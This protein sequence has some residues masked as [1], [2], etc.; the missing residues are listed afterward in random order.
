MPGVKAKI[1]DFPGVLASLIAAAV[2][3]IFCPVIDFVWHYVFLEPPPK[4]AEATLPNICGAMMVLFA[5]VGG[6]AWTEWRSRQQL[7]K[8]STPPVDMEYKC[9]QDALSILFL[10]GMMQWLMWLQIIAIRFYLGQEYKLADNLPLLF[11]LIILNGSRWNKTLGDVIEG[12]VVSRQWMLF[13]ICFSVVHILSAHY[14]VIDLMSNSKLN[15]EIAQGNRSIDELNEK[16]NKYNGLTV[17]LRNLALKQAQQK[18]PLIARQQSLTKMLQSDIT[19]QLRRAAGDEL[20]QVKI[21]L[22]A[23]DRQIEFTLG[24]YNVL[25]PDEQWPHAVLPEYASLSK[26]AWAILALVCDIGTIVINAI[27]IRYLIAYRGREMP[28]REPAMLVQ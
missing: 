24:G 28:R 8:K 4:W 15:L 11:A 17:E 3:G 10:S 20:N 7:A 5:I 26:I 9:F 16:I 27:F 1:A 22:Q 21:Q 6:G 25:T 13:W 19:P 12:A 23:I 18:L 14:S 2:G